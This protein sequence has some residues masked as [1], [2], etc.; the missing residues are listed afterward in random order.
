MPGTFTVAKV[1]DLRDGQ[2]KVVDAGGTPVALVFARGHYHAFSNTCRH[3]G[4]PIGEGEVDL[5]EGTVICPW[6]GW[7]Y[8]L[9]SGKARLNPLAKLETFKVEVVGTEVRVTI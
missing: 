4:G 3:R 9:G 6:H 8:E 5:E 2:A 7:Q 1:G